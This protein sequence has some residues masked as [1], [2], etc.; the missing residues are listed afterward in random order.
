MNQLSTV[1][2]PDQQGLRDGAWLTLKPQWHGVLCGQYRLITASLRHLPAR[3]DD[4]ETRRRR[5]NEEK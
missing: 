4:G 5:E 1:S 3:G 2:T